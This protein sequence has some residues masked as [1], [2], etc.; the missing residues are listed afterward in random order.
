MFSA[1]IPIWIF[2]QCL[3]GGKMEFKRRVLTLAMLVALAGCIEATSDDEAEEGGANS[4]GADRISFTGLVADGY[5]DGATVCLDLD[6]NKECDPGEPT[7]TSGAGGEFVI[8][9]ATQAQRDDYPLL[10]VIE[11]GVTVD[12]D[13]VDDSNP[14]G[15]PYD[16]PLTLSAPAGFTF[17]SPLSTMVQSEIEGGKSLALAEDSVQEQLGTEIDLNDDYVAKQSDASLTVEQRAEYEQ[18]HQVA[19]VTAQVISDN[20]ENLAAAAEEDDISLD[21]LISLIVNEVFQALD[22]ITEEVEVIA[23]DDS[24]TF[25]ADAVAEQVD[26]EVVMIEE[27]TLEEQVD[28]NNASQDAVATSLADVVNGDGVNWFW[29]GREDGNNYLEYGAFG[30]EIKEGVEEFYDTEYEWNGSAFVEK[31]SDGDAGYVLDHTD[32]WIAVSNVDALDSVTTNEDGS[33]NLIQA[34]GHITQTFSGIETDL[35]NQNVQTVLLSVDDGDGL[36]ANYLPSGLVF[37]PGA[38]GYELIDMTEEEPYLFEDWSDC[39]EENKVGGLCAYSFV[40]DGPGE[41]YGAVSSLD[42]IKV[43]TAATVVGSAATDIPGIKA[44]EVAYGNDGSKVWAEIVEGGVVN[45]YLVGNQHDSI[46]LLGSA[47]WQELTIGTDVIYEIEPISILRNFDSEIEG[48]ETLVLSVISGFVRTAHHEVSGGESG[49]IGVLNKL[50]SEFV[51]SNFN[52]DNIPLSASA[53]C[54]ISNSSW[55]GATETIAASWATPEQYELAIAN[56]LVELGSSEIAYEVNDLKDVVATSLVF[57]GTSTTFLANG[58][59]LFTPSGTWFD[60][61]I[62]DAHR[63]EMS[64]LKPD[65]HTDVITTA[66]LVQDLSQGYVQSKS[67]LQNTNV[68]TNIGNLG[69]IGVN[70]FEVASLDQANLPAPSAEFTNTEFAGVYTLSGGDEGDTIAQLYADGTGSI[71]FPPSAED[72]AEDSN[73]TGFDDDLAWIMDDLGRLVM[74]TFSVSEQEFFGVDRYTLISGNQS[75][76][77][78]MLEIINDETNGVYQSIGEFNWEKSSDEITPV[79]ESIDGMWGIYDLDQTAEPQGCFNFVSGVLTVSDKRLDGTF[80][81]EI[82]PY[83]QGASGVNLNLIGLDWVASN[84]EFIS[85]PEPDETITLKPNANCLTEVIVDIDTI[86]FDELCFT[87]NTQWDG[88]NETIA[89]SWN[90]LTQ[91]NDAVAACLTEAGMSEAIITEADVAGMMRESLLFDSEIHVNAGNTGTVTGA[92]NVNF[93]WTIVDG[94]FVMTYDDPDSDAVITQTVVNIVSDTSLNYAESK[95]FKEYSTVPGL[96]VIY[97]N[98]YR[99]AFPN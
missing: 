58:K 2:I 40:Q 55:D 87:G 89:T 16:Q 75:S 74:S 83:I 24:Q 41:T 30:F 99:V 61:Q 17:I 32:G 8:T 66:K 14:D 81:Q 35:E 92:V 18:L 25:D 86:E 62:N 98:H 29:S 88:T 22:E 43:A 59:G 34:A 73:H 36:W 80:A 19:Q 84:G 79:V 39:E 77:M 45:Y 1:Q 82:L 49:G 15:V 6:E 97:S 96:G 3:L 46:S 47:T 60:W 42:D 38:K 4:D 85:T 72:L 65:G 23:N 71:H 57:D 76:G 28:L 33:I 51:V 70:A 11:E 91:F 20:L 54:E 13:T 5:L 26:D 44:V 52:T 21:D 67:F 63:L 94:R 69:L 37:P 53:P 9:D 64:Y 56:C 90:T 7:A 48:N 10:V 95:V 50:A 68:T 93:E 31:I 12:E 27:D 78:V